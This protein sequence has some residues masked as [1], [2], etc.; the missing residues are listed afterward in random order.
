MVMIVR[1]LPRRTR[2]SFRIDRIRFLPGFLGSFPHVL[3]LLEDVEDD[4][5]LA[6]PLGLGEGFL[7]DAHFLV[8]VARPIHLVAPELLGDLPLAVLVDP[9]LLF[10]GPGWRCCTF[11]WSLWSLLRERAG[12]RIVLR[13]FIRLEY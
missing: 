12:S 7:Q 3:H 13:V 9:L 4:L 1:N 2:I 6:V 11:F 8:M 5:A 10:L